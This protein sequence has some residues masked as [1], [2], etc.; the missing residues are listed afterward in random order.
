MGSYHLLRGIYSSQ[1]TWAPS[2]Y[3]PPSVPESK[4]CVGGRI[5]GT[6]EM[7]QLGNLG[8]A[9]CFPQLGSIH[10]YKFQKIN[11]TLGKSTSCI[12]PATEQEG[13]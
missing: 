8:A 2:S 6:Q 11:S 10:E 4:E 5:W 1:A 12:G 13:F 7:K 3:S 9:R